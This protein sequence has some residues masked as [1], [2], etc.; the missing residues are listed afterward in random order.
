MHN[1][2]QN[3]L[4][5][6]TISGLD[7]H[8]PDLT[9][10]TYG[11]PIGEAVPDWSRRSMPQHDVL[12][13]RYCRLE[14]ISLRHV[15]SL[16]AAYHQLE[17]DRDW[18][19]LPVERPQSLS[20]FQHYVAAMQSFSDP[21]HYAIV[22]LQS[23]EALGTI[24]L[25]RI[26]PDTGV[27]EVG[28]VIYSPLLKHTAIATEAQFLLMQYVFDTLGYRRYEWKCDSLNTPS[29][30]AA[31]RLGFSFEGIFRQALVYK[32]RNRDTAWFSIINSEWSKLKQAYLRWLAA[33]NF[34]AQGQQIKRL[35]DCIQGV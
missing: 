27:I 33:D 4:H 10:N 24:A 13:G 19:Y 1:S 17:D 2:L 3:S 21:Q 7:A 32:G 12:L 16:F 15:P 30:A 28:Y 31:A 29:R 5:K 26:S 23:E 11:Q 34:D 18:T 14:P 9:I 6:Q 35:Q 22:D 8:A 20:E 25:M